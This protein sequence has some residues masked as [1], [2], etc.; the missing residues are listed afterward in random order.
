MET[1]GA[2]VGVLDV[3]MKDHERIELEAL[4]ELNLAIWLVKSRADAF[5][6]D[7]E[8][9]YLPM[10]IALMPDQLLCTLEAAS[11]ILLKTKVRHQRALAHHQSMWTKERDDA[12][13]ADFLRRQ[14]AAHAAVS[15]AVLSGVLVRPTQCERCPNEVDNIIGHHHDY[16][17]PLEVEWLCRPCHGKHHAEHG[18]AI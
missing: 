12:E 5:S 17:K 2:V 11:R 4:E 3:A 16:S 13:K 6:E 9:T 8:D 7:V 15:A 14:Q 18:S 1:P 10:D